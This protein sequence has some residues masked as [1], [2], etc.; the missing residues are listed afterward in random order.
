[1]ILPAPYTPEPYAKVA[2]TNQWWNKLFAPACIRSTTARHFHPGHH[3]V[4]NLRRADDHRRRK[5]HHWRCPMVD[6]PAGATA[7]A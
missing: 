3:P 7:T 5:T 6:E 1:M 4:K 2:P